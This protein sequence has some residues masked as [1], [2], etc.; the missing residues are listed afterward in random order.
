MPKASL[1]GLMSEGPQNQPDEAMVDLL[2]KQVTEGLSPDE[3]RAL[4]VLDS[5]V[6]SA[7]L[8]E[9]ER[10]AAA[11]AVAGSAAA[12]RPPQELLRRLQ[13][14]AEQHFGAATGAATGAAP[15]ASP[16]ATN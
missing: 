5:A 15:S 14:Q 11:I 8:R 12:E 6:A 13:Q 1:R 3:Q 16:A 10:A 4:D 2:I 9:L 7:H